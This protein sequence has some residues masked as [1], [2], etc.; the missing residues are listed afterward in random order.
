MKK[1]IALLSGVLLFFYT[2]FSQKS[3]SFGFKVGVADNF[4]SFK[5]DGGGM[6][7]DGK[8]VSSNT[9]PF[10]AGIA[11]IQLNE[12]FAIQPN[13]LLI[14]KGGKVGESKIN[15]THIDIPV[16]FLYTTNGF[17]VGGGPNF[18]YGIIGK[19]DLGDDEDVDVYDQEEAEDLTLQKFEIGANLL[20]GYTC[21]SGITFSASFT[22]GLNNIYKG[23]PADD[24]EIIWHFKS[25]G[26]SVGYL[27][28][29]K[30]KK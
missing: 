29:R 19:L 3:T 16:N 7:E 14:M 28:G 9:R 12:N 10:I 2:S 11:H 6:G 23:D 17:F 18:S 27:F 22:P 26:F 1:T 20:I 13:L 21:P 5:F 4:L 25:F 30:G 24:E 15:T 8:L